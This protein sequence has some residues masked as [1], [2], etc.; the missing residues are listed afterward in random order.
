[1]KRKT[2]QKEKKK[3]IRKKTEKNRNETKGKG[4]LVQWVCKGE[5][6]NRA[7][8]GVK[9]KTE[10]KEKEKKKIRKKTEKNRK[11]TKGKGELVQWACTNRSVSLSPPSNLTFFQNVNNDSFF[12][13]NNH[14]SP[15]PSKPLIP[16]VGSFS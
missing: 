8:Y 6:K 2:E 14:S 9:R 11:E 10:Q 12:L 4:E 5:S 1:M 3:K 7:F 15:T 16:T 13:G